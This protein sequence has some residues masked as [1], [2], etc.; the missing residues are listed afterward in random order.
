MSK[1][2][3]HQSSEHT[4]T[5]PPSQWTLIKEQAEPTFTSASK[6]KSSMLQKRTIPSNPHVTTVVSNTSLHTP[7]MEPLW[8]SA[9]RLYQRPDCKFTRCRVPELVPT[10]AKL[11]QRVT[12]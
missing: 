11:P 9:T 1:T 5:R 8:A 6:L 2:R 7:S 12:A 4:A 10:M 3:T